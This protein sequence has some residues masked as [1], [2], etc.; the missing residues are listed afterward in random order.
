M[1]KEVDKRAQ[2]GPVVI[3]TV[4]Q[5]ESHDGVVEERVA[6]DLRHGLSVTPAQPHHR[7][8]HHSPLRPL[9]HSL[10]E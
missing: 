4:L 8:F 2:V 1:T 6:E 5:D 9:R 10:A 7:R 3:T